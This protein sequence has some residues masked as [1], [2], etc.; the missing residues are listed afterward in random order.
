VNLEYIAAIIESAYNNG[1]VLASNKKMDR[2]DFIQ[3]ARA[4]NGEVM[5]SMWLE[6]NQ[7]ANANLYFS[8]SIT[9]ETFKIEK[10]GRFRMVQLEEG[11]A[12]KLPYMAGILRVAP[13]MDVEAEDCDYEELSDDVY[14]KGESGMEHTFGSDEMMDDIGEQF[15]IPIG[16]NLRLFGAVEATHA[17]IDYI[18]NDDQLDIP[19]GAAWR[20][21]NLVLG[22]VL[23]VV[24][25]PVDTTDD[26]NPNV[27]TIKKQI[28]DPQGI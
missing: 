12:V 13:V 27:V 15:Y 17:E 5:R 8:G 21:I 26:T 14:I 20:I 7:I 1:R 9:T 19:E 23:K 11:G 18:K 10:K 24:G 3:M 25:F 22:P 2:D 4:A 16:N 28:A 6:E